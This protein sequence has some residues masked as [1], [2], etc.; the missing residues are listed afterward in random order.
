MQVSTMLI[1]MN[2]TCNQLKIRRKLLKMY[3][4]QEALRRAVMEH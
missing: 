3:E 1:C 4:M 2:E